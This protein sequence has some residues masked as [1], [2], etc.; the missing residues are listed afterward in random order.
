MENIQ[1][2]LINTFHN[3]SEQLTDFMSNSILAIIVLVIG[4]FV[5]KLI[6]K[7]L[8]KALEKSGA[9]KLGDK[10]NEIDLIK[11]TGGIKLR[12][13][14]STRLNSSHVSQSRMPSSA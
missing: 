13:R 8:Q 2:I 7:G 4:I 6:R 12:D 5:A 9:D 1:D 11:N 14:K 3:L 10:L